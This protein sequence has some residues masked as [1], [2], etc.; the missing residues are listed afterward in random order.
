MKL[1][2]G[3]IR[4]GI[5]KAV[6]NNGIIKAASPGLFNITDNV[7]LL[8]PIM[9]WFIGSNSNAFSQ[10][11]YGDEVWILSFNDNPLQLFWFKKEYVG[12]QWGD[13]PIDAQNVEIVCNRDTKNGWATIYFSDGTGWVIGNGETQVIL[14]KDGSI[15]LGTGD[16]NRYIHINSKNISIGSLNESA[17]P[18]AFGDK[19]ESV[20]NSLCILLSNVAN[21]ALANP[22]TAAIGTAILTTLPN[23]SNKIPDISSNNVTID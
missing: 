10:P 13:L 19:T 5:V 17:H 22:Y 14:A 21:V 2:H 4:P 20:F 18:A 12:T 7:E 15:Q 8:P 1:S 16:L 23:I 6:L 9:P 11:N 3:N